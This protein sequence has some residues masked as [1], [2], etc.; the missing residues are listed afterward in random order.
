[1][2][3]TFSLVAPPA[4]ASISPGGVLSVAPQ[5]PLGAQALTVMA[6]DGAATATKQVTIVVTP[7]LAGSFARLAKPIRLGLSLA[8][9]C[10]RRYQERVGGA[11][12][13]GFAARVRGGIARQGAIKLQSGAKVVPNSSKPGSSFSLSASSRRPV[14]LNYVATYQVGFESTNV[15]TDDPLYS[16]APLTDADWA[17]GYAL[18]STPPDPAACVLQ[19]DLY[20]TVAISEVRVA[21][22][23]VGG[24]YNANVAAILNGAQLQWSPTGFSSWT[25]VATV[26]GATNTTGSYVSIQLATPIAAASWR[27]RRLNAVGTTMFMLML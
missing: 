16:S 12:E 18:T 6:T 7:A 21:G 27:L 10:D 3:A 11:F 20:T 24:G 17:T 15:Y 19:A 26:S 5:A 4:W 2:T 25:T 22:G 14:V 13:L 1:M 8:L 9:R 23:Y